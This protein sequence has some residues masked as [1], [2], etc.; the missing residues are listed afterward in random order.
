M[1]MVVVLTQRSLMTC[2]PS[3]LLEMILKIWLI[4]MTL[5]G[6]VNGKNPEY[7]GNSSALIPVKRAFDRIFKGVYSEK[8]LTLSENQPMSKPFNTL[9]TN[10]SESQTNI[11]Y[12]DAAEATTSTAPVIHSMDEDE[13]SD[14]THP[15]HPQKFV[16]LVNKNISNLEPSPKADITQPLEAEHSKPQTPPPEDEQNKQP[17]SPPNA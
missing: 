7:L 2:I 9:Q 13:D 3:F 10:P 8:D 4:N 16:S 12:T 15:P 11:I 1:A 6:P 17:S 14:R 5:Y